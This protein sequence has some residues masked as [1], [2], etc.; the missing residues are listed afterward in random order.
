MVWIPPGPFIYGDG[1]TA[2]VENQA[3]GL[4]MD[5]YP[6]T[7]AQYLEFLRSGK[8][9]DSDWI[10]YGRSRIKKDLKL[11]DTKY[12]EHPVTGVSWR[13]AQA[14]AQWRGKRLPNE[15]EWEKAARGADGREYPW[16][17]GFASNKCNTR[18]SGRKDTSPVTE[19]GD[20]VSPYGCWDMAGNVWEW[21]ENDYAEGISRKVARGGSWGDSHVIAACAYR[22]YCSPDDRNYNIGF[23]CART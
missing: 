22:D 7:N 14:Y 6:V 2:R 1:D 21:M 18:E 5:K 17:D 9:V 12:A 8:K 3:Q 16:G 11:E 23:R 10:D 15:L 20:G 19:Y 13:G 4:W